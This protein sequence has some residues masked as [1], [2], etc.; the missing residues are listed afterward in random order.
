MMKLFNMN[1]LG[2]FSYYLGIEVTQKPCEIAICQSA[3]VAKIVEQ[4][5][6]SGCN[7]TDTPMEQHVR[8]VSGTADRVLDATR[9]RR[10]IGSLR[11][12]VNTRPDIAY[13]VGMAS[14]FMESPNKEHWAVVKRI[15]R[16][17]A[18]T[19]DYGCKYTKRGDAGL[20]LLGYTD[21][22]HGGDL[23]MRRF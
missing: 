11:Y 22:D 4:R 19:L 16:Y 1:D 5:G 17:V 21:S 23:V 18:G 3:Y 2:L 15:V 8:P 10:V 6:L 20:N 7:P 14:R 12:L 13:A 9:Y